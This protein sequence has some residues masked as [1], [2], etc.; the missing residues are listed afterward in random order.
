MPPLYSLN[1]WVSQAIAFLQQVS[2]LFLLPVFP[3]KVQSNSWWKSVTYLYPEEKRIMSMQIGYSQE[4]HHPPSTSPPKRCLD[5][6]P[7]PICELI[8][9]VKQEVTN[10]FLTVSQ[11]SL[12]D[13]IRFDKRGESGFEG[14][15]S[16]VDV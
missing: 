13:E 5:P 4:S 1:E 16:L 15:Y 14:M 2:L 8:L 3:S 9:I 11:P 10:S 6:A 7:D 12:A